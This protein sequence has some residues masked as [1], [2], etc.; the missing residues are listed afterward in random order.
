[1]TMKLAVSHVMKVVPRP[2]KSQCFWT[3]VR[4]LLNIFT[5]HAIKEISVPQKIVNLFFLT[6]FIPTF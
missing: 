5:N 1:M 4:Y 6:I 2:K 3:K